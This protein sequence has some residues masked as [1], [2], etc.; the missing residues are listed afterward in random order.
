MYVVH[1]G[2]ATQKIQWLADTA[3]HRYDPNCAFETGLVAEIKLNK[4]VTCNRNGLIKEDLRDDDHVFV[5][6]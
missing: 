6:L 1:C 3:V 4:G 2:D 5:I